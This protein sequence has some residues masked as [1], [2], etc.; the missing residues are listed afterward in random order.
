MRGMCRII[1]LL[2]VAMRWSVSAFAAPVDQSQLIKVG[3]W[4]NQQ[5]VLISADSGF[6]LVGK[7]NEQLARFA[8]KEKVAVAMKAGQ[9]AINGKQV[10]SPELRV[11]PVEKKADFVIEVNKRRYRGE[12]TL[13]LSARQSGVTVINTIDI[14]QYLYGIVAREISPDWPLEAI[15]AQAVAARS[16]ALHNS[17]KHRN[18]G[19]DV[20]ATTDCQVYN[21]IDSEAA[22]STKAVNDTKGI[23]LRFNGQIIPAFF[24]SSSGG[25]T[26]NSE[27]VWG[28]TLPYIR[29]VIDYDQQSPHF[30]WSKEITPQELDTL[31]AKAGYA[32]G[33]IQAVTVSDLGKAPLSS[34]D[35]GISGRI[36]S[37]GFTGAKGSVLLTGNRVRSLFG[38]NSTLFDVKIVTPTPAAID[39]PIT[40]AFGDRG[41]KKIEIN[42]KPLEQT[43]LPMDQ[44]RI[45]RITGRNQEKIVFSGYGWGHGLG[46]SQWGAKAMA[47]KAP[48]GDTA[49]FKQ[50]LKHYYQGV[51]IVKLY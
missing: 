50:I 48:A 10:Q 29:G 30:R 37:I 14:E 3:L 28:T 47:E 34:P 20:C 22:R 35:R 27:N 7:N 25:F 8:A 2:M 5:S 9:L 39:V 18:D 51:D 23:I 19:Y 43:G 17:K 33:T 42:V 16:Y 32:I 21:G 38:L 1:I 49:Y 11:Q 44:S 24:H 46:L 45:H 26:E 15:K 12:I 41:K 31:L 4:D 36:K 13:Q 6:V 40:D